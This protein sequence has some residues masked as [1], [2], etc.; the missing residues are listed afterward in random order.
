MNMVDW[1]YRKEIELMQ[2][3]IVEAYRMFAMSAPNTVT[4]KSEFDI[5]TEIDVNIEKYLSAKIADTF[6]NDRI[7]GE[8]MTGDTAVKER[9]WT[10]DPID[11]TYNMSRGMC[12]HG[13][14]A[15]LYDDGIIVAS[16]IYLPHLNEMYIAHI[17]CGAY[18][19]GERIHT[20]SSPMNRAS[21]SIGD[22]PHA[23]PDDV[24]DQHRIMMA[25]STKIARLRMF[26]SAAVDF[27]WLAAGR[28]D[29][30][31]LYTKNKWDIAPGILLAK[32]AGAMIRSCE[33]EYTESS[34]AVIAVSSEEIYD[35]ILSGLEA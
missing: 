20:V 16:V 12:L 17:G 8:E 13:V 7:L 21:V 11:G 34:R 19:N 23:R 29:G 2:C 15:A 9:T 5:V 30:V 32:E 18:L 3:E 25:L 26:G 22:F 24:V 14:Q 27:S 33:G 4:D 28:T 31:V 10:L 6:S 1:K 35:C